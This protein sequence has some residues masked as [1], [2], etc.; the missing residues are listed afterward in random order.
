MTKLAANSTIILA[1]VTAT[2]TLLAAF[3]VEVTSAQQDAIMGVVAALL[4]LL[5]VYF[6]PSIPVGNQDG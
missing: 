3:G 6:H 2:I 1:L 5:G 4:L